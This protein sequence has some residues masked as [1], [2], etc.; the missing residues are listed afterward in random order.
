ML[1]SDYHLE[2]PPLLTLVRLTPRIK[3]CY[4]C[5]NN[6]RSDGSNAAKPPYDLVVRYKERRYYRDPSTQALKLTNKE[7]TYYH[8][9]LKCIQVKYPSF[10]KS[11]LQIP[12]DL[13]TGLLSLHKAHLL[14]V[15]GIKL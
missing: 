3:K 14:D 10:N 4:G 2:D 13:A 15:F 1:S 8:F 5:G 12:P 11:D 6:I 7:N 9:M